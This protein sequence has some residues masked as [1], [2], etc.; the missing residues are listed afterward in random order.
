MVLFG[1]NRTFSHPSDNC[2]TKGVCSRTSPGCTFTEI[3][4][5]R[6]V[7]EGAR[8]ELSPPDLLGTEK[9]TT[10]RTLF[11]FPR[12]T[13]PHLH[14]VGHLWKFSRAFLSFRL[15]LPP[16]PHC[17]RPNGRQSRE[18]GTLLGRKGPVEEEFDGQCMDSG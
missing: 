6:K 9:R 8:G 16:L 15:S 2:L 12:S 13:L 11:P 17:R 18:K 4:A 3:A 7:A 1:L 5:L 10:D 14:I